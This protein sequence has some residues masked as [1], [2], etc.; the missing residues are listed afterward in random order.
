MAAGP[1]LDARKRAVA[2]AR[3]ILDGRC[4]TDEGAR[5]MTDELLPALHGE[6]AA[7]RFADSF[8]ETLSEL[9]AGPSN[10]HRVDDRIRHVAWQV[11]AAWRQPD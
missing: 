4:P 7:R 8:A 10:R 2:C 5:R 9:R 6:P 3:E 1:E 11:V